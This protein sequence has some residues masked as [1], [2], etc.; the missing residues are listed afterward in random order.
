MR[1]PGMLYAPR[2]IYTQSA[3]RSVSVARTQEDIHRAFSLGGYRWP[4]ARTVKLLL[5]IPVPMVQV[6]LLRQRPFVAE[7]LKYDYQRLR[8]SSLRPL[9]S[10]CSPS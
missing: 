8:F 3:G 5:M 7:S 1:W 6:R 4:K 10:V 9:P 2:P